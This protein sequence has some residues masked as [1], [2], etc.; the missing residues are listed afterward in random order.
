MAKKK[1][2]EFIFFV[3]LVL[4]MGGL[5][6][7][8]IIKPEGV[9]DF[10]LD[11]GQVFCLLIMIPAL[12]IAWRED[13]DVRGRKISKKR[14]Y[15][16]W[17]IVVLAAAMTVWGLCSLAGERRIMD[18]AWFIMMPLWLLAMSLIQLTK[19]RKAGKARADQDNK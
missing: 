16:L 13:I 17:V 9:G 11:F 6:F 1:E 10:I 8:P 12:V 4:F 19:Y 15:P 3:L 14:V 2:Y 7:G 5:A 18:K